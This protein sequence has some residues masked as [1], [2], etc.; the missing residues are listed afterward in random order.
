LIEAI[1][2]EEPEL[3]ALVE[4]GRWTDEAR[5]EYKRELPDFE[6]TQLSGGMLVMSRWPVRLREARRLPNRTTI[7]V[8]S[9]DT[10]V[11]PIGMALADVGSNPLFDRKP[12]LR[13]VLEA[14]RSDVDSVIVGDFNTPFDSVGFNSYRERYAHALAD[15]HSGPIE[16]W[17]YIAPCL[18]IDHVWVSR[19]LALMSG[20]K[21][22]TTRSDHAMIVAEFG[23]R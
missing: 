10:S 17:P 6:P 7:H 3:V 1:R 19:S 16:T 9:C 18:A 5:S 15:A 23:R 13:E 12:L 11:G 14:A 20:R 8:L 2:A 4:A 21:R 22:W